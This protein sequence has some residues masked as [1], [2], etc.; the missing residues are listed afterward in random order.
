MI[1]INLVFCI[2]GS[3]NP[4]NRDGSLAAQVGE[5]KK[6]SL[7]REIPHPFKKGYHL[8]WEKNGSKEVFLQE[9]SS[10][11]TARF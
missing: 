9:L 2:E 8:D 6:R 3:Q 4:E 5:L 11:F 10:I 1:G 7:R